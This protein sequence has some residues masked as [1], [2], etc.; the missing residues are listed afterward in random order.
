MTI[1]SSRTVHTLESSNGQR[2]F[3]REFGLAR[4]LHL[5]LIVG[6]ARCARSLIG[7]GITDPPE[8]IIEGPEGI[9]DVGKSG[10]LRGEHIEEIFARGV[11]EGKSATAAEVDIVGERGEELLARG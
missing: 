11:E 8:D 7:R 1:A 5:L 3:L 10:G 2:L 6:H 4:A 9:G